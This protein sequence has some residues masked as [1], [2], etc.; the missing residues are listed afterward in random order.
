MRIPH[1]LLRFL[2]V[3]GT[4]FLAVAETAKET[5]APAEDGEKTEFV[6]GW[7]SLPADR[8]KTRGGTSDGAPVTLAP[9]VALPLP[10]I[11]S[12]A[13]PFERDRAAILA[14]AGDYR[15]SFHFIESLGLVEDFKPDRPYH[16][17]ATE[18]VH[19]LE[20]KGK[21]ISLQ[22]TL[23]MYFND[24]DGKA[25]EPSLVK[26]WRQDWTYED[27][28]LHPYLGDS[29]W[30]HVEPTEAEAAGA[31][32]QAVSG[33]DDGPRYETLGRWEH[34]GNLSVWTSD[35]FWRPLPR[36]EH[37]A[38][39]DYSVLEGVHRIVITP[40]GWLHEQQNWKRVAGEE[41]SG[42]PVYVAQEYGLDR[43]ERI[44]APELTLAADYWEKTGPFWA[45]VR[46][47]WT[48]TLAKHGR[49]KLKGKVEGESLYESLFEFAEDIADGSKAF[50]AAEAER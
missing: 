32:S 22:H 15:V 29:T 48:E 20:D 6:F 46:K 2:V 37:S 16:S 21:F 9:P 3:L 30:G 5:A 8:A 18:R 34:R 25:V 14:L 27:R 43:Y 10:S 44:S 45:I 35:S 40:T 50:D 33:V 47:I 4:P 13:T 39:K 42:P 41:N 23:E 24:K 28:D 38:R 11:A 36:R 7:G 31:W 26:H 1:A 19:V 49:L 12:A 17:W